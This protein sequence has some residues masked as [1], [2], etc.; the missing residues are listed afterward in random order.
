MDRRRSRS[1]FRRRHD[2]EGQGG[3]SP[4][5]HRHAP[6]LRSL[7][8]GGHGVGEAGRALSR[9]CRKRRDSPDSD[10]APRLGL[11]TRHGRAPVQR[12]DPDGP[13]RE[14]DRRQGAR[15]LLARDPGRPAHPR[16]ERR[17]SL[18]LLKPRGA[19][20]VFADQAQAG[21]RE[22]VRHSMGGQ[23]FAPD[24]IVLDMTRLNRMSLD[25]QTRT[26]T[27]QSGATWHDIQSFLHPRF[28]VMAMQSTDIFTVGGSIA[29][30]AHGMDHQAGSVGRTIR[31][32]RVMLADGSIQHVSRTDTPRL[33]NLVV[34]G[35]GLFGAIVDADLDV[36]PNVG[37]RSERRVIR[38]RDFP[39][40]FD[41]QIRGAPHYGLMYGHL[42]T[43]PHSFLD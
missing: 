3:R 1:D 37:Y 5:L 21:A 16:R 22:S 27:V 4:V 10:R 31:A 20:D 11:S 24:A 26:L 33:F 17:A 18:R 14:A 34:G 43:A 35:Y 19:C 12:R 30:N 28:A 36:T 25:A 15:E 23:A 32:M 7:H 29:V 40:V 9:P 6:S 13:G 41:E 39:S 38:Y 2:P 8:A 42:S